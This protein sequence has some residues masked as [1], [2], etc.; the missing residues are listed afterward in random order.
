MK[1]IGFK[2]M[3]LVAGAILSIMGSGLLWVYASSI[4]F[5]KAIAVLEAKEQSHKELILRVDRKTDILNSKIDQLLLRK[6]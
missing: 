2:M 4:D 3:K 1:Q 6:K 5:G